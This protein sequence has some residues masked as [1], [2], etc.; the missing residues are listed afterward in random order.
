MNNVQLLGR[1]TTDPQIRY[2]DNGKC[3]AQF[4]LAVDRN[5]NS[6][7]SQK[8]DFIPCVAFDKTAELIG[9]N[10]SKGQRLLIT[11][12]ALRINQYKD[13]QGQNCYHTEVHISS[14]DYVEKK[15]QLPG[16]TADVPDVEF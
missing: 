1:L 11:M 12:G 6:E 3:L 13:K 10:V 4:I 2:A 9:N 15:Y 14:F 8:T 7:K 5:K 16:T